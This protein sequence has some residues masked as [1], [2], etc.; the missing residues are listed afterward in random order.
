ME[1]IAVL[2]LAAGKSSRMKSIKQLEKINHNTLLDITLEKAKQLSKSENIFCVLGANADKIQLE[3]S[4]KNINFILNQNFETGLSSS[5]VAG[6]HH[7]KKEKKD[8]DG[9]LILLADQPAISIS[10]LKNICHLFYK[11]K[12]EI[13]ASNYGDFFGTPALFP[14]SCFYEL[15]QLKGDKGAKMY[16]NNPSNFIKSTSEK[17]NLIDIDTQEQLKLFRNS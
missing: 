13:V 17:T 3:I 4:T 16:L 11:N 14:K 15:M 2:V 1:K 8:F 10:Y 12:T 7:F 6:I 5:I 9:V